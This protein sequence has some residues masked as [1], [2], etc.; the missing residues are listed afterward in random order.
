MRPTDKNP[1][2]SLHP[3]M[4]RF[5]DDLLVNDRRQQVVRDLVISVQCE[6]TFDTLPYELPYLYEWDKFVY[7]RSLE[8]RGYGSLNVSSNRI[9][10]DQE[11]RR[12]ELLRAVLVYCMGTVRSRFAPFI[13]R[14]LTK[15]RTELQLSPRVVAHDAGSTEMTLMGWESGLEAPSIAEL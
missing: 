6:G 8:R 12:I 13:G 2:N 7:N 14:V 10:K 4:Q 9:L 1:K 15:V 5:V 11:F 3:E